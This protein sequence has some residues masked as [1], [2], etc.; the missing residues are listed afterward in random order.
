MHAKA[1][2]NTENLQA[3][4]NV[5]ILQQNNNVPCRY[6]NPSEKFGKRIGYFYQKCWSMKYPLPSNI[7]THL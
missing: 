6:R 3:N 2:S 4:Q 7:E 1:P 5:L